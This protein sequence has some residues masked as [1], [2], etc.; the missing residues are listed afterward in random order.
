MRVSTSGT[1]CLTSFSRMRDGWPPTNMARNRRKFPG[2]QRR[3]QKVGSA[4]CR[5][6]SFT[7]KVHMRVA[8]MKVDA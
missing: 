7:D 1:G 6:V 8:E 5:V 3:I 4:D 2:N